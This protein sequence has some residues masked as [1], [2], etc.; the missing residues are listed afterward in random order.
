VQQQLDSGAWQLLQQQLGGRVW[1]LLLR[2][3]LGSKISNT[4]ALCSPW[5]WMPDPAK[6]GIL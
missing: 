6:M 3:Q 5:L 2:Q 4:R 1:Q